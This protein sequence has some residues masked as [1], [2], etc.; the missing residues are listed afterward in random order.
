MIKRLKK[1]Q[2]LLG[3]LNDAVVALQML[4]AKPRKRRSKQHT[5]YLQHQQELIQT[6]RA[7]VPHM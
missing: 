5:A 6:L 7:K 1:L 4:A 2:E 3:G